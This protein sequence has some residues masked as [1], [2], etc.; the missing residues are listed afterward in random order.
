MLNLPVLSLGFFEYE[1]CHGITQVNGAVGFRCHGLQSKIQALHTNHTPVLG[2]IWR[3]TLRTGAHFTKQSYIYKLKYLINP[4]EI[5][6][7]N[8]R[9]TLIYELTCSKQARTLLVEQTPEL[10]NL[11]PSRFSLV[12]AINSKS[13]FKHRRIW[14]GTTPV[15]FEL[16]I[17]NVYYAAQSKQL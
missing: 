6:L 17:M 4:D 8:R 5:M 16:D 14:K 10:R 3:V 12:P 15:N 9:E 2:D 13:H 7:A 1:A 11:I